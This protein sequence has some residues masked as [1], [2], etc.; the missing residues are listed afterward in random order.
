MIVKLLLII[1]KKQKASDHVIIIESLSYVVICG[2][3]CI[4][5]IVNPL[6]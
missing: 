5:C 2:K 3:G 1:K 6:E 4:D